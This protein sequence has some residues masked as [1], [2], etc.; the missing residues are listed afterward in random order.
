M[1]AEVLIITN[2]L[3]ELSELQAQI[4]AAGMSSALARDTDAAEQ[5][6]RISRPESLLLNAEL[7]LK[8]PQLCA[9]LRRCSPDKYLP[10][11]LL[12]PQQDPDIGRYLCCA[13]MDDYLRLPCSA[14]ELQTRLLLRMRADHKCA[15]TNLPSIDYAYLAELSQLAV[16]E[17]DSSKILRGIVG[18]ISEI[19][20][21]RRCS[22][23][24]VRESNAV[25]HVVASSDNPEISGLRIDL[26]R[27]PEIQET[28]RTG[29]PLLIDNIYQHPLMASVRPM[30]EK[31]AYN[32]ILVLPMIDG[33]RIVG[34]LVL[35][36]ARSIVGFSEEEVAFCQLVANVATSALR[37]AEFRNR[38]R[39]MGDQHQDMPAPD[40][41]TSRKHASLLSMAAHDLRVLV[42]VIDGYCMLLGETDY[43]RLSKEQNEIIDGLM[44]SS[45]RLV[46]MANNLLDFA[47]IESGRI[48]LKMAKHDLCL[49][50]GSVYGEILPLLHRRGIRMEI[51][52]LNQE[53]PVYCDDQGIS[54]VLHNIVNNA[55]KFTSDGGSLKL[56]LVTLGGEARVSLED[57][58]PGIKPDLLGKLFDEYR[59]LPSPDG[60]RGNGLGL[61]ICK[62]I[63]EAHHGRIWAESS[64]GQGSRFTFCLPM[65]PPFRQAS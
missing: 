49:I 41:E 51:D 46:D 2:D 33:E 16:T 60:R 56:E 64:L 39:Q 34:V 10:I 19:I 20:E 6:I 24:A 61:T 14:D 5:A 28:L 25:G 54:R 37:L 36:A 63:V 62:R 26:T 43:S 27:Y 48:D 65:E 3:P 4:A 1:S 38:D 17:C 35:R 44:G 31:L 55:L 40:E 45:R 57:N 8:D 7:T 42:S 53:V 13:E 32:S 50:I 47:R 52:C 59:S 15:P 12:I 23:T 58:G 18:A 11:I 30:I 21:V 22:I 9:R 29:R